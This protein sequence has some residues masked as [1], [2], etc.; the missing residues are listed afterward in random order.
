MQEMLTDIDNFFT[1]FEREYHPLEADLKAW[2]RYSIE[3]GWELPNDVKRF[4]MAS[5]QK[6]M[7]YRP[8]GRDL[9]VTATMSGQ[10]LNLLL[11]VFLG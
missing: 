9:S 10:N 4:L 3:M 7:S 1:F 8:I 2:W 6:A 5:S 11:P